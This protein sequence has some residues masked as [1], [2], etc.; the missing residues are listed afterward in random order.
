MAEGRYYE[1]EFPEMEE[2]VVV[3]VKR[4]VDMG[5]YVSLLEYDNQEAAAVEIVADMFWTVV[6]HQ[7]FCLAAGRFHAGFPTWMSRWKLGAKVRISGLYP[8]YTPFISRLK[9]I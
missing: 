9:P 4:I 6:C 7:D 5:A 3:Q 1:A 8:Q 2:I